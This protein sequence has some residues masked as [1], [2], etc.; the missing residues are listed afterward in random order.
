[1]TD[2]IP[3]KPDAR[4]R[5]PPVGTQELDAVRV[6]EPERLHRRDRDADD[7]SF[8]DAANLAKALGGIRVRRLS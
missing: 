2:T 6:N 3:A 5:T 8:H 4:Y 1:M 7:P